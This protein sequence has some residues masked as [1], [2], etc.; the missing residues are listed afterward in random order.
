M[1]KS[2]SGGYVFFDQFREGSFRDYGIVFG[3]ILGGS[4]SFFVNFLEKTILRKFASRVSGRHVFEGLSVHKSS[5]QRSTIK[6][7]F[8]RVSEA[9]F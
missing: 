3:R 2:A 8:E 1:R 7:V 6:L 4:G 5:K 9:T